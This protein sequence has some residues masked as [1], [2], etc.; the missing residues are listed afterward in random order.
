MGRKR[1]F[2]SAGRM[3]MPSNLHA[4]HAR[5]YRFK[6]HAESTGDALVRLRAIKLTM[7]RSGMLGN[8]A[9]A[10]ATL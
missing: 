9:V 10:D 6:G 8:S 4:L 1:I 3:N 7:L 2:A 5:L